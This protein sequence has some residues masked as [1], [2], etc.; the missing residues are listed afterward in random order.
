[1]L[2]VVTLAALVALVTA[3]DPAVPWAWTRGVQA[4]RGASDGAVPDTN[5]NYLHMRADLNQVRLDRLMAAV[6]RAETELKNSNNDHDDHE[7][8]HLEERV[9]KLTG[10]HIH[11]LLTFYV[12]F[13]LRK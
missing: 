5:K 3:A 1:M 2:I 8:D 6:D 7:V 13:N 12:F 10:M 11:P 4:A 9:I